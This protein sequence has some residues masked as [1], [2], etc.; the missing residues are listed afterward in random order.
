L[1]ESGFS[2]KNVYLI[3]KREADAQAVLDE[4]RDAL[5]AS[6]LAATTRRMYFSQARR[7][8]GW[9]TQAD[10]THSPDD[11]SQAWVLAV[12]EYRAHLKDRAAASTIN[13][14]LGALNDFGV[15]AL[16]VPPLKVHYEDLPKRSPRALD[17]QSQRLLH[18]GL[19]AATSR[20]RA[21]ILCS[22]LAGLRVSEI[23]S[24]RVADVSISS[25]LGVIKVRH[26]KGG[27]MREVPLSLELRKSIAAWLAVRES[28]SDALFI[29]RNH[30][31]LGS[32]SVGVIVAKFG[33]QLGI[34]GLTP[35]VLRHT[36]A[37]NMVHAGVDLV[38]VST[39]LGHSSLDTTALYTRPSA[40]MLAEAVEMAL[41]A[42]G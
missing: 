29:G 18:R 8:V 3:I 39:M 22:L 6:P 40:E 21:I 19:E 5:E 37:T 2:L 4:Y 42:E 26:G 23:A 34:E 17:P 16:G 24:L 20:D 10:E 36:F 14:T 31:R 30:E 1:E 11:P 15:R 25:R 12:R 38:T 35:H 41:L 9:L 27:K 28:E 32:R 7:F 13:A 33:R